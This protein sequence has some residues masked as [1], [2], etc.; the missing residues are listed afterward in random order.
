MNIIEAIKKANKEGKLIKK[1]STDNYNRAYRVK[2]GTVMQCVLYSNKDTP[3]CIIEDSWR[4]G[5]DSLVATDWVLV[6]NSGTDLTDLPRMGIEDA[7][8]KFL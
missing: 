8:E 1:E 5:I 4:L 2:Y 6:E 3:G 7:F